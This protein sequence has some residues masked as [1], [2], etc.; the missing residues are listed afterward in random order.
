M[1]LTS[2]E[3]SSGI[4]RLDGTLQGPFFHLRFSS[5][6]SDVPTLAVLTLRRLRRLTEVSPPY[7]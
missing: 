2:T 7:L 4:P 6:V 3:E 5:Q 1:Q